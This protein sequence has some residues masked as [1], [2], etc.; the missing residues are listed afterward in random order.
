MSSIEAK[1]LVHVGRS[2]LRVVSR[3]PVTVETGL[4]CGPVRVRFVVEKVA[5]EQVFLRVLR[6]PPISI[7]LP[8]THAHLL[9][10]PLTLHK[11]IS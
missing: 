5:L 9:C 6:L 3:R 2:M 10:L 4:N 11:L 8:I 1:D 7:I